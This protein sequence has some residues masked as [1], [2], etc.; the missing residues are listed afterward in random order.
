[1]ET[2][3][4][5]LDIILPDV[6]DEKDACVQRII[7]SMETKKGIEKVHIVAETDTAK[8][9]LCFHYNPGEI[10]IAGVQKLAV[11]AGAEIAERL[12]IFCWK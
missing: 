5:D 11:Q 3:K 12:G 7:S 1:M 10:S 2:I 9:K 6:R 4:I 8:A